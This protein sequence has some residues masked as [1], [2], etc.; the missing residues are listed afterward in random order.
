MIANRFELI[1]AVAAGGGGIV[2]RARDRAS[3]ANVAVKVLHATHD[4][5]LERFHREAEALSRIKHPGI[6]RYLDNGV[7]DGR[8]YIVMDWI[9]GVS[10]QRALHGTHLTP[11]QSMELMI[12]L[13]DALAVVHAAGIVHRDLK[14]SN[15][16]LNGSDLRSPI[17]VDFGVAY[18][19]SA[20]SLTRTGAQVGTPGYMAPELARGERNVDA[21]ADVFAL[22]CLLYR[23]LTGGVPFCGTHLFEV[24]SATCLQDPIPAIECVDDLPI[25]LPLLLDRMIAKDRRARPINAQAVASSLRR[26]A[27]LKTGPVST[28]SAQVPGI[29]YETQ[30]FACVV[31]VRDLMANEHRTEASDGPA[32]GRVTMVGPA[33]DE[34]A[35]VRNLAR[36]YGGRTTTRFDGT[37]LVA[38]TSNGYPAD[39][40][41]RAAAFAISLV[42][43]DSSFAAHIASGSATVDEDNVIGNPGERALLL[44]ERAP[45]ATIHVDAE[46]ARLL[47][48]R[49]A[50]T[51]SE[52]GCF[53]IEANCYYGGPG[54]ACGALWTER[55][56]VGRD[57][58]IGFLTSLLEE[59]VSEV[60]ARAVRVLGPPGS[61]KSRV[62]LELSRIVRQLYPQAKLLVGRALPNR[63]PPLGLLRSA[64]FG[65]EIARSMH[66]WRGL[67][68]VIG[69]GETTWPDDVCYPESEPPSSN[70]T[71]TAWLEWLDS[72]LRESPVVLLLEDV[73][74]A[75]HLSAEHIDQALATFDSRSLFVAAFGRPDAAFSPLPRQDVVWQEIHLLPLP[76][77]D[78]ER[79]VTA[80][81]EI[82]LSKLETILSLGAGIPAHLEE[83]AR[84]VGEGHERPVTPTLLGM[85]QGSFDAL[86]VDAARFLRAASL[87]DS[88]FQPSDVAAVL[89]LSRGSVEVDHWIVELE[90]HRMLCSVG[91]SY[92][93]RHELVREA[94]YAML[95]EE[96]R[97]LA[98]RIA[99]GSPGLGTAG[100]D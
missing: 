58:E 29:G 28:V 51:R 62:R 75:D 63:Q 13:A 35:R 60:K 57:R 9:E 17:L 10:L 65:Q 22:G 50:S 89:G 16:M 27:Q 93:F 100:R 97:H 33:S 55:P 15:V 73:H 7:V 37:S 70:E 85:L 72:R 68:Y 74:W 11:E 96:D 31:A 84:A 14:P 25:G 52:G 34:G 83:I 19:R 36:Y 23:C 1:Q 79:L 48:D 82:P 94:A 98:H 69:T 42:S 40:A 90:A 78:A 61:G 77:H 87:F 66:G 8:P 43:R 49:F 44:L 38:F 76:R 99:S 39:L 95:T 5:D 26:I 18:Y 71:L 81:G 41:L 56:F 59:C 91:A 20:P 12:P 24:L 80:P 3:G 47:A 6:V 64:F 86:S 4:A 30:R 54:D 92:A 32:S 53:E 2:Y 88:G 67:A 45:A 46:V 21:R